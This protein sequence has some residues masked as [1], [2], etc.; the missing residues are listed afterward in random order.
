MYWCH[1]KNKRKPLKKFRKYNF[2]M[3]SFSYFSTTF[4]WKYHALL[5]LWLPLLISKIIFPS[6][7]SCLCLVST[8]F[9]SI[10]F[11][12]PNPSKCPIW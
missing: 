5:D 12:Q 4:R 6:L 3:S 10:V 1:L 2:E 9:P 11:M 7:E 8:G